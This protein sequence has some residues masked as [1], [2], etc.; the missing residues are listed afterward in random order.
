[1]LIG[2]FGPL[3]KPLRHYPLTQR[4]RPMTTEEQNQLLLAAILRNQTTL[5]LA[6]AE[7]MAPARPETTIRDL[8]R[9]Y[10]QTGRLIETLKA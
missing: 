9:G 1:M 10:E 7:F 6:L 2:C 5:M 3:A 4:R 8:R